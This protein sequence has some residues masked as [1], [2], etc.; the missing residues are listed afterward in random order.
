MATWVI[1]Y[2]PAASSDLIPA[3]E[4]KRDNM[5]VMFLNAWSRSRGLMVIVGAERC[6]HRVLVDTLHGGF[7]YEWMPSQWQKTQARIT[8]ISAVWVKNWRDGDVGDVLVVVS[9]FKTVCK[10]WVQALVSDTTYHSDPSH[11]QVPALMPATKP[12]FTCESSIIDLPQQPRR[13]PDLHLHKALPPGLPAT[14]TDSPILLQS[15]FSAHLHK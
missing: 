15:L 5:S 6:T 9:P 10:Q 7:G 11:F 14:P 13:R 4:A 1:C 8:R 12:S 3:P 2:A